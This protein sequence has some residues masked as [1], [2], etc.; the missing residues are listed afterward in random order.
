VHKLLKSQKKVQKY[1]KH[2][3]L[4]TRKNTENTANDEKHGFRIFVIFYCP[5]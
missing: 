3:Q 1:G 5:Y 2:G 4:Y